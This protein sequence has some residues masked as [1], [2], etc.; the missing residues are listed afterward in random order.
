MQITYKK[1]STSIRPLKIAIF[2]NRDSKQWRSIVEGIIE[3]NSTIWGGRFNIIIPTDGKT[4]EDQF[5]RV[6]QEFN[7]DVCCYYQHTNLDVLYSTDGYNEKENV[8]KSVMENYNMSRQEAE[9]YINSNPQSHEKDIFRK[10]VDFYKYLSENLSLF[11]NPEKIRLQ[12]LHRHIKQ[13]GGALKVEN[14]LQ[15]LIDIAN[16]RPF[17]FDLDDCSDFSRL[18]IASYTGMGN[19]LYSDR[20]DIK[21]EKHDK[22]SERFLINDFY[23]GRIPQIYPFAV[24]CYGLSLYESLRPK[25]FSVLVVGSEATDFCLFYGL[26]RIMN[27]IFWIPTIHCFTEYHPSL[28]FLILEKIADENTGN[29]RKTLQITSCSL[30]KDDIIEIVAKIRDLGIP[31]WAED[32]L[33]IEIVSP[34]EI[35]ISK[36]YEA[37]EYGNAGNTFIQQFNNGIST[38]YINSPYPQLFKS[39]P[40]HKADWIIDYEIEGVNMDK[41]STGHILPNDLSLISN[42]FNHDFSNSLSLSII[43]KHGDKY[44]VRCPTVAL[45]YFNMRPQDVTP[46]PIL[47]LQDSKEIFDVLFNNAGYITQTSDKGKY[48]EYCIE[49]FGDMEKLAMIL[50]NEE[51]S[52][53]FSCYKNTTS[54]KRQEKDIKGIKLKTGV[55]LSYND[56]RSFFKDEKDARNYMDDF[57][58][59]NLLTRGFIFKCEQC[60]NSSWYNINS[61]TGTFK[62]NR[63]DYEQVYLPHHW[64]EDDEPKFYYRLNEMFYQGNS[65]N[66]KEPIL[67]ILYLKSLAKKSFFYRP[68]LNVYNAENS[69]LKQEIDFVCL[70][71]GELWIG[72]AKSGGTTKGDVNKYITLCNKLKA[73]FILI[74][75][76]PISSELHAYIHSIAWEK[77]PTIKILSKDDRT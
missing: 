63:C 33:Q 22:K 73:R 3:L 55:Y 17:Y 50:A 56:I 23:Q 40:A 59:K 77:N 37:Y 35:M 16:P 7:P 66:M 1:I 18:L 25:S 9:K 30:K 52:N 13:I 47:R 6:L 74:S 43:R 60:D 45:R 14:F 29:D 64:R 68:E 5:L 53:L 39:L 69:S 72:E 48:L 4:V 57:I 11:G 38:N 41:S 36:E 31:E 19:L 24:N 71:D 51:I 27:G 44:S 75:N 67:G 62:C 26:D 10:N 46:R 8:I 76:D 28:G 12:R 49:M 34:G 2:F 65:H 61:V 54:V 58:K 42:L 20:I 21:I 15:E 32:D 70:V